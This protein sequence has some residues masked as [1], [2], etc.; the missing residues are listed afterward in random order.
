MTQSTDAL[1]AQLDTLAQ[2]TVDCPACP[3]HPRNI[4]DQWECHD[5]PTCHGS[6]KCL[7]F[8]R[9]SRPCLDEECLRKDG[10]VAWEYSHVKHPE[11]AGTHILPLPLDTAAVGPLFLAVQEAVANLCWAVSLEYSYADD[12]AWAVR[13]ETDRGWS[14]EGEGPTPEAALLSALLWA[15]AQ[16]KEQHD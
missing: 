11:C 14:E 5:C 4:D 8:P 10:Y 15:D 13:V 9:L 6:G 3:A 12:Y 16:R 2:E 1:Q 7:R